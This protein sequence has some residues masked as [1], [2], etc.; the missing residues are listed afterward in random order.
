MKLIS[1]NL[2]NR[3]W[4]NG[5]KPIKEKI[6]KHVTAG[7]SA[8]AFGHV[9]VTDSSAVTD[10]TG[11][12]LAATE[13]NATIEGTLANQVSKLN[14]YLRKIGSGFYVVK[15]LATTL[16]YGRNILNFNVAG[17]NDGCFS[18]DTFFVPEDGVYIFNLLFNAIIQSQ[19]Y[20]S[21]FFMVNDNEGAYVI[22]ETLNSSKTM[23]AYYC[24]KCKKGDR[25]QTAIS[26]SV[27]GIQ[28]S[29]GCTFSCVR[30]S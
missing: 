14:T 22:A 8:S 24:M 21:A 13:K 23:G 3:F 26:V 6:E 27:A 17:W 7:A 10:S 4:K 28:L 20:I 2:L 9:K 11:R 16:S 25:I 30:I 5:V 19:T 15:N 18:N 1:A 12:A 29:P